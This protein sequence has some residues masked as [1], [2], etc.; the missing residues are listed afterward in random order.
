MD[1]YEARAGDEVSVESHRLRGSRRTGTILEVMGTPGREYYLVRWQDGRQSVLH[2]GPDATL[3]RTAPR[4]RRKAAPQA[5]TKAAAPARRRRPGEPTRM[6]PRPALTAVPG[7]RLV[8]KGHH[9]GD[10]VRDAEIL[11]VLGAG[12]GPPFR[13]RWADTGRET[14]LFPG[15]DA[16]V[17]HIAKRSP[18]RAAAK[19]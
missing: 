1:E 3:V 16:L 17:D 19:R 9:L 12:G 13:V 15:P 5:G 11:E 7:D 18:R 14:L 8:V 4:P 6:P 10:R 2:P